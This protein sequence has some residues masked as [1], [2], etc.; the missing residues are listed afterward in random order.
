MTAILA[1][2]L[3]TAALATAASPTIVTP[4]Q[5]HWTAGTGPM[6]GAEIAVLSGNPDKAGP[7][8]IR[9]RVPDGAKFGPH[10]HGDV[11]N[12]TVLQGTLLVGVGDKWNQGK[13]ISLPPGSFVSVPMGL[14][15]YAMAK[16]DVIIQI[17][18][19]GPASMTMVKMK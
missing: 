16:G 9:L 7:Y 5:V 12:V 17:H 1:S 15:H 2:S 8:T 11:E 4:S 6:K 13:M 14:H 10:W 18:G 3:V 19:M